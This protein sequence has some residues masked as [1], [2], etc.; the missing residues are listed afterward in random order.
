MPISSAVYGLI[1]KPYQMPS[2]ADVAEQKATTL[3]K[4]AQANGLIQEQQEKAQAVQEAAFDQQTLTEAFRQANGN[5]DAAITE[6]ERTKPQLAWKL[7]TAQQNAKKLMLDNLEL[8]Q[9]THKAENDTMYETLQGIGDD[10]DA[11]YQRVLPQLAKQHPDLAA[12]LPKTWSKQAKETVLQANQSTKEYLDRRDKARE[13]L[14]KGDYT[15]YVGGILSTIDDPAQRAQMYQQFQTWVPAEAMR[16]FGDPTAP[17]AQQRA[18]NLTM[19]PN[20][21]ADNAVAQ[22]NADTAKT[23]AAK[24]PAQ[25]L[26]S[27][28]VNGKLVYTVMG[29]DGKLHQVE[30]ATPVPP[31]SAAGTNTANET[32]V[33]QANIWKANQLAALARAMRPGG[34][35]DFRTDPVIKTKADEAA[36]RK[37]IEDSYNEMIGKPPAEEPEKLVLTPPP[38]DPDA[39]GTVPAAPGWLPGGG[40]VPPKPLTGAI[41][42]SPPP[43]NV[44]AMPPPGAPK[45]GDKVGGDFVV[46]PTAPAAPPPAAPAVPDDIKQSMKTLKAGEGIVGDNGEIFQKQP[47]GTVKQVPAPP[48]APKVAAMLKDKEPAI[49]TMADGRVFHKYANGVI[50]QLKSKD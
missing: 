47:D 27:A 2:A 28:I 48:V 49:Y 11:T 17:D 20:E 45:V 34:S 10:D 46:K 12:L 42:G 25:T 4:M 14:L 18:A 29:D 44:P 39:I 8:D 1:D 41:P 21:R 23:N 9:K 37:R 31:A 40:L 5:A 15:A 19:K 50:V 13:A 43:F 22:E 26:H 30:G 24:K 3:G 38:A 36:E 33:R 32:T 6:I 16:A 7:R 35:V